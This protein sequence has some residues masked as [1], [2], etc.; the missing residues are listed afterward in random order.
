[1]LQRE[2]LKTDLSDKYAVILDHYS[3]EL[4]QVQDMYDRQ[5]LCPP[6]PRDTPPV[7]GNIVWA[8]QLL[9]RVEE[10]MQR[11]LQNKAMLARDSKNIIKKY[12]K[13]ALT[14]TEYETLWFIAW[15][16]SVETSRAGLNATLIVR[17]P[18]RPDELCVNFDPQVMQ[19]LRETKALNR[20]G[21][22][23]P[24][25]AKMLLLQEQKFKV[26]YERT[27]HH[28]L[29]Y[30]R[31]VSRIPPTMKTLMASHLEEFERIFR[32]GMTSLTWLS[33]N[34]DAYLHKVHSTMRRLN[35]LI[36][37]VR[38]LPQCS[39]LTFRIPSSWLCM[40]PTLWMLTSWACMLTSWA[41]I[42][43]QTY[44]S[45]V[46]NCTYVLFIHGVSSRSS[47]FDPSHAIVSADTLNVTITNLGWM[48][49]GMFSRRMRKT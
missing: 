5:K 14:L 8:R 44:T 12:N 10:P 40:S 15:T 27:R 32:P 45:V 25:S 13:I 29:E 20:L 18:A 37:K 33:M 31:T 21:I 36:S 30:N 6:V 49:H 39:C 2:S 41:C 9:G 48:H 23:L 3:E 24:D 26:C 28:L 17:N 11:F 42:P 46:V 19:L 16:K 22:E 34:I 35:E 7:A 43:N 4:E 1:M 47:A 38:T